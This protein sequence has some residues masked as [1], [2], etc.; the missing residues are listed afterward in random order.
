MDQLIQ[1]FGIDV[2]LIIIQV[3]NFGILMA[4]LTYFLYKPVLKMLADREEK[5]AQGIKDA[6]SAAEAL[7]TAEDEK[8]TILTG[9]HKEAEEVAARAKTHADDKAA[10]ITAAADEKASGIVA[11]AE[12]KAEDIKIKAHKDSE[13]EVAKLAVL[14]AEKVLKEQTS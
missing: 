13:S 2:K 6:E 1:A 9:A 7:A 4:L 5:I 10:S 14:A 12:Q 11:T 8:Q 3:F